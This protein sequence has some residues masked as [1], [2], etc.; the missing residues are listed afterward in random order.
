MKE[1]CIDIPPSMRHVRASSNGPHDMPCNNA[2]TPHAATDFSGFL[3]ET[4]ERLDL[5]TFPSQLDL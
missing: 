4:V 2:A 3:D 5:D 1:I